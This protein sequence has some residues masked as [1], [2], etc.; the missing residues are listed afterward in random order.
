MDNFFLTYPPKVVVLDPRSH[1]TLRSYVFLGDVP[2]RI[3][4]AITTGA[5][6]LLKEFYG[7]EYKTKLGLNITDVHRAWLGGDEEYN[8]DDLDELLADME[9]DATAG[10]PGEAPLQAPTP[11]ISS[12]QTLLTAKMSPGIEYVTNVHLFPEDNFAEAKEKIYLA[13]NI[14]PYRQHLFYRHNTSLR[15]T[16]QLQAGGIYN[17]DIRQ[18]S[19]SR[20]DMYGIPID[21]S[22]YDNRHLVRINAYDTFRLL[23]DELTDG[24]IHV[25]DLNIFIDKIHSQLIDIINDKYSFEMFYYSF[26]IKYWPH[27]TM[28]CFYDF[29]SNESTLGHKY[30]DLAKDKDMLASI[31]RAERDIIVSKYRNL[32]R[33][34]AYGAT[35]I[36]YA[37]TQMTAVV[38]GNR[39]RLNIR[40]IF[41][42]LIAA[43]AIPEIHA[44]VDHNNHHYLL[45]KKYAFSD[46]VNFPPG[47]MMK[48]GLTCA[49]LVNDAKYMFFNI[50]PNGQIY[51]RA[52]WNEED[53]LD[54]DD[55]LQ[56]I[57][58]FTDPIVA[59]IN[60]MGKYAFVSGN[61]LSPIS[62][63]NVSYQN[64]NVCCFWKKVMIE[65]TFKAV[66]AIW[67][68][69]MAAGITAPRNVQQFEKYEFSFRKGM[70]EFD[71]SVVE[72]I[73]NASNNITLTNQ[74]MYLSNNAIKQKWDQHYNGR[75]VYM[76]HRTTDVRFE[77]ANIREKE[78]QIFRDFIMCY[79]YGA[80]N[81]EKIKALMLNK[82]SYDDVKKLRKLKE[83]DPE[84][85]NLKKY[86]SK[87]VYSILCQ[88]QRQPIIYTNDEIKAMPASDLKMLTKYWNF[89]L[90]KPAYYRCPNKNFPHLNFIIGAHPKHYCLPC[91]NKK[92]LRDDDNKKTK[93]ARACLQNHTIG[94]TDFVDDMSRHI[95]G[96]GK[97]VDVGRLSKI[98]QPGLKNLLYGTLDDNSLD[99]YLVGVRQHTVAQSVGIIFAMAEAL[100]TSAV[101]LVDSITNKLG[102]V[103]IFNTMMNGALI[104]YFRDMQDLIDTMRSIVNPST[105]LLTNNF[106]Q[107]P[108]LFIEL[109]YQILNIGVFTFIDENGSGENINLYLPAHM[110]DEIMVSNA[111]GGTIS[112]TTKYVVIVKKQSSYYPVF[113]VDPYLY[114]KTGVVHS[115]HFAADSSIIELL[116]SVTL[117]NLRSD[118]NAVGKNI[119]LTFIKLFAADNPNWKI[120]LK[121]INKQNLC[122]AV[123]MN[124]QAGDVYVP[125]DYSPHSADST[126]ITFDVFKNG[127]ISLRSVENIINDI[128]DF[129]EKK[130]RIGSTGQLYSYAKLVPSG[131]VTVN[132][133]CI[134]LSTGIFIFYFDTYDQLADIPHIATKYDYREINDCIVKG[135]APSVDNRTRGIGGALYG[136]HL[137]KLFVIEFMNYVN[138]E[139]NDKLRGK[140]EALIRET[141][142]K[143]DLKEFRD[144]LNNLLRDFPSD[145]VII[146]DHLVSFYEGTGDKKD[147]LSRI[148]SAQYGFDRITVNRLQ[149]M[150]SVAAVSTELQKIASDFTVRMDLD[151]TDITFPNM[152]AVCAQNEASYCSNKKLIINQ[153]IGELCDILAADL[154]NDIKSQ[155]LLNSLWSEIVIDYMDFEKHPA[156]LITIFTL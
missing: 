88:N 84:L 34:A 139:K 2:P 27:F 68:K 42:K 81:N 67:D 103:N 141:N 92:P 76:T 146:S 80:V 115:R 153:P 48:N 15:T 9:P 127:K 107:W 10:I 124:G 113:V 74:Y 31:Y 30:P 45:R 143:K 25:V 53:E 119:D 87:K 114:F 151:T 44:Y 40:N 14:P 102:T 110:Y 129:I 19:E 63:T 6:Q 78:F 52:I 138:N 122:Y 121:F 111:L 61:E 149:Q 96:Y 118:G 133:H 60:K 58:K 66:R 22:I 36:S 51:V 70:H 136:N 140:I 98:P 86:G 18:I 37:I 62:K 112:S 82:R 131:Y 100:S 155:Y 8:L 93:Q 77:V 59:R 7:P 123:I 99:Y 57:K 16:Y 134:G 154:K 126:P 137:Y 71:P 12:A 85:Y 150:D 35:N 38:T 152:Y 128:N 142:F 23:G 145:M 26:V 147:L 39:V 116:Y 94:A 130:Y 79:V 108:E 73:I 1:K 56:I 20:A 83:Q 43:A 29:V 156:E 11:S 132:T 46:S 117:F 97:D 101:L 33:A 89:T 4:S 5:Y 47:V 55:A 28:E 13:T 65:P 17:V 32:P 90:E 105:E 49:V 125:C 135:S 54:F 104:M 64:L 120:A 91:C 95:M 21:K 69:Y 75:T 144:S 72:K 24:I 109:F 50:R 148:F 41:D 3:S 106:N